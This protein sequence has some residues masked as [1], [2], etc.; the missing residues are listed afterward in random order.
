MGVVRDLADRYTDEYI[1]LDPDVATM[2]GLPGHDAELVL[3]SA[4]R[5]DRRGGGM[6]GGGHPGEDDYR[7][8]R[9][10]RDR[11]RRTDRTDEPA[12]GADRP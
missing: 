10:N 8:S 1:A 3:E 5:P 11:H 4:A 6:P 12:P 7:R 9:R 2:I